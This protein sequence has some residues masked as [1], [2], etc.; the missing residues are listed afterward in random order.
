M[1]PCS[2]A[3]F[4]E[5]EMGIETLAMIGLIGGGALG[6]VGHVAAAQATDIGKA[7]ALM[8]GQAALQ[9]SQYNAESALQQAASER[10][11][12]AAEAQDVTRQGTAQVSSARA[13]RG[14][15]G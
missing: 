13:M 7:G 6:A 8:E 12:A 11:A 10:A 3:L 1:A 4:S 5:D 15:T 14:A 2:I 9:A